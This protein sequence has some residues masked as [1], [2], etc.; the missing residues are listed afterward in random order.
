MTNE[1]CGCTELSHPGLVST[2]IDGENEHQFAFV[3]DVSEGLASESHV[4]VVARQQNVFGYDPIENVV[5]SSSDAS[6]IAP[7]AARNALDADVVAGENVVVDVRG[8]SVWAWAEMEHLDDG[9][10]SH[11]DVFDLG[12]EVLSNEPDYWSTVGFFISLGY[13]SRRTDRLVC[14]PAQQYSRKGC[15]PYHTKS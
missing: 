2:G 8:G 10:A 14:P 15:E 5:Y 13:M 4:F 11:G 7:C 3:V 12:Y 1:R 9:S 6:P